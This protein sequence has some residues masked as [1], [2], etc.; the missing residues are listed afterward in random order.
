[1]FDTGAF[2]ISAPEIVLTADVSSDFFL[3]GEASHYY[4][5]QAI[6]AGS[7]YNVDNGIIAYY[8]FLC[9]IAYK[10]DY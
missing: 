8:N 10:G 3:R 5:I 9:C 4:F 7:K 2:K 6:G 1:M